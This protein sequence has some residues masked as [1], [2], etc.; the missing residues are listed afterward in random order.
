MT[1]QTLVEKWL[2]R[3]K[4]NL[5]I[6]RAKIVSEE[7]LYEDLC[8]DCQQVVEKSLKALLVHINVV[9]P[10]THSITKLIEL[11][12]EKGIDVPEEVKESI[13]LTTYAVTTRYPGDY[14]SVDEEEYNEAVEIAEKV[15]KWVER[16]IQEVI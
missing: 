8:F 16:W 1:N 2:K 15:L 13:S 5:E 11:I 10:W 12:E 4:S 9:F 6:A 3:A 7:I 14:E